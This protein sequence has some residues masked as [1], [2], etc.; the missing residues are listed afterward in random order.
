MNE[1]LDYAEMLEIPV[2]TMSVEKKS[3]R[4]KFRLVRGEKDLKDEVVSSVNERLETRDPTYAES[5]RIERTEEPA[6]AKNKTHSLLLW[7]EFAVACILC[8]VIFFTNVFLP[9]SAINTF[10]KS[11]FAQ[12]ETADLRTYADFKL[13]PVVNE[14]TE[15]EITVSDTGVMSFTA[16]CSVYS[17]ADGVVAAING[18]KEKGY[19]VEIHHSEKFY[20]IMSGLDSV[21]YAAG[22]EVKKTI[23]LAYSDGEGEV[24]V[25]FYSEGS[26]ISGYS[27]GEDGISWS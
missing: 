14:F 9:E 24:R 27:V 22:E 17:P 18:D 5:T 20:T 21:Y 23:P 7:G 3:K 25:M 2:E 16:K 26:L 10:V 1:E 8:A 19:T 12:T 13:S 4:K 15:A 6:P 11:L